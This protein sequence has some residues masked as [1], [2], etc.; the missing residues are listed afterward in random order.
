MSVHAVHTSD[1]TPDDCW[2]ELAGRSHVPGPASYH[3]A[4]RLSSRSPLQP[5]AGG[6]LHTEHLSWVDCHELGGAH[7]H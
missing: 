3:P 2:S 1:T 5:T 6:L 4:L 7:T